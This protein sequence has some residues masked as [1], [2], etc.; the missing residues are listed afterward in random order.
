MKFRQERKITQ[1]FT[2]HFSNPSTFVNK[3]KFSLPIMASG[4]AQRIPHSPNSNRLDSGPQILRNSF[5]F[6]PNGKATQPT[7][8]QIAKKKKFMNF[9]KEWEISTRLHKSEIQFICKII[10]KFHFLNNQPNVVIGS[11]FVHF[12]SLFIHH[13]SIIQWAYKIRKWTELNDL[14]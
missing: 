13:K 5:E 14:V 3:W 10:K 11:Q 6:Q 8:M 9:I 1:P 7:I 4:Y 12:Y 2:I